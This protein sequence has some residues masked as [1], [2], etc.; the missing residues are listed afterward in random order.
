M[1]A[2]VLLLF[3]TASLQTNLAASGT[4]GDLP[5]PSGDFGVSR[6]AYDWV[7][8][9]RAETATNDPNAHREFADSS[10]DNVLI[11]QHGPIIV[12]KHHSEYLAN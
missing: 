2:L 10:T 9:S 12:E 8:V 7:D 4:G 1:K 11:R 5:H 3:L 6:V